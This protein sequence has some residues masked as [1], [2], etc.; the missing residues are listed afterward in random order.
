VEV[1]VDRFGDLVTAGDEARRVASPLEAL[2]HY[3]QALVLWRGE[4]YQ[5]LGDG[6]W[7]V[8]ERDRLRARFVWAAVQAA[9]IHLADGAAAR[10]VARAGD[11]LQVEPWSEPAYRV[12]VAAHLARGDHASARRALARCL[13]M[14]AEVG[15]EPEVE[16]RLVQRMAEG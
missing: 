11:A 14:L 5:G 9:E 16:T 3:E 13:A 8:T 12:L 1:D 6:A 4:P 15:A 10:A 7:V 2:A